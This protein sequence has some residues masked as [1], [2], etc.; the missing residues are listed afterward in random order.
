MLTIR[1]AGSARF[2]LGVVVLQAVARTSR[3]TA[4]RS[5]S[6]VPAEAKCV[7][8]TRGSSRTRTCP[9]VAHIAGGG[10]IAIVTRET[11]TGRVGRARKGPSAS[12]A[13]LTHTSSA[14]ALVIKSGLATV[15]TLLSVTR[16][17]GST[18]VP[19]AG[20]TG[21]TRA[22][23]T[24]A[25]VVEGE[26]IAIVASASTGGGSTVGPSAALAGSGGAH[27]SIAR[28]VKGSIVTVVTTRSIAGNNVGTGRARACLATYTGAGGSG[29]GARVFDRYTQPIVTGHTITGGVGVTAV[30]GG[31]LT[32]GTRSTVHSTISSEETALAGHSTRSDTIIC[33]GARG[34]SGTGVT[35]EGRG[36][37]RA[38][39]ST[40]G[41]RTDTSRVTDIVKCISGTIIAWVIGSAGGHSSDGKSDSL[42]PGVG[43][44]SS[45]AGRTFDNNCAENRI[46]RE[47]SGGDR[48]GHRAR[49]L[50]GREHLLPS[51]IAIAVQ[52]EVSEDAATVETATGASRDAQSV[53][54]AGFHG[55]DRIGEIL[56]GIA[57]R[58]GWVAIGQISERDRLDD[59]V[60]RGGRS[61]GAVLNDRLQ[62]S[63]ESVVAAWEQRVLTRAWA[64]I[65]GT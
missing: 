59:G 1:N 8:I 10:G 4:F 7:S 34:D 2:G 14:I 44:A 52:V 26:G 15:V 21:G 51:K 35:H 41:S 9:A 50:G 57:S 53:G 42:T 40:R 12:Q 36:T 13:I 17:I 54:L 48:D 58:R 11:V 30:P 64:K 49:V 46:A 24:G 18:C 38:V 55:H 56:S 43:A 31:R 60:D 37:G 16:G 45:I 33:S 29:S 20:L 5:L 62:T 3:G 6:L 47:T 27:I 65:T 32:A 39:G 25:L 22:A 63:R 61:T 23:E 28:S 19:A